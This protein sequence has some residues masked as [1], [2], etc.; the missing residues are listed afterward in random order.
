MTLNQ[1]IYFQKIAELENM[2]QASKLLHVSQPSLSIAIANLEK[3][4][5]LPLFDRNGHTIRLNRNGKLFLKEVTKILDDIDGAK[6]HMQALAADRESRI[7]IGCIAPVLYDYLPKRIQEFLQLDK[8]ND[9]KIEFSSNNTTILID[10]LREG[11][12][13]FL[14]CS[15][16]NGHDLTQTLLFSEPYVLLCPLGWPIPKSWNDLLDQIL[17]GFQTKAAAHH[18]IHT[19]LIRNALQPIY[20]YRAP[21][22]QTIASLVSHGF[23]YGI[24]PLVDSIKNYKLQ[25]VPLPEPNDGMIRNIYLTQIADHTAIGASNRFI[26]FLLDVKRREEQA[27]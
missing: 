22:E 7:R 13:D 16:N 25:I 19:M 24:V 1:L 3:E 5:S 23:G 20:R 14:I 8:R 10:Q 12:F 17:I 9:L 4:L 2:G 26:K 27:K 15:E 11:Y 6:R 18:E 21:D